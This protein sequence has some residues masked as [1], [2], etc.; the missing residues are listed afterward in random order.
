MK[1]DMDCVRDILL[2]CEDSNHTFSPITTEDITDIYGGKWD[3]QSIKYTV[4]K[5]SEGGLITAT[6][7]NDGC[8]IDQQEVAIFS[9][10]WNGHQFLEQVRDDKRWSGVKTVLSAIRNYSLSA[11]SS[12]AEGMTSA[13]INAYLSSQK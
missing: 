3:S 5:M 8:P 10:T 4:S 1:L 6:I 13:A 2:A 12:V 9:I 11:I 7:L